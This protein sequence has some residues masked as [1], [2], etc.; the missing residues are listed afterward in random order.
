MPADDVSNTAEALYQRLRECGH[1]L[2]FSGESKS[3]QGR[4]LHLL[5][6]EGAILQRDLQARLGVKSGSLSEILSK[7]EREGL[8][9]RETD[10]R[11]RRRVIV[12]MTDAGRAHAEAHRQTPMEKDWFQALDQEQS[13]ELIRLL[14]ILLESW[15]ELQ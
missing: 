15:K 13:E 8:I 14:D 7:L 1:I 10:P 5:D 9:A 4:I 12:R 2:Y 11:D 3:G 6:T